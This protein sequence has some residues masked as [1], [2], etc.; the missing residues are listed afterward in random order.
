MQIELQDRALNDV[1]SRDAII[2][3]FHKA[4][5][6]GRR[7][8]T[9]YLHYEFQ[10]FSS[11]LYAAMLDHL[12]EDASYVEMKHPEAIR[13]DGTSSRLALPFTPDMIRRLPAEK[14]E[15]WS[16]LRNVLCGDEIRDLFIRAFEPEL[17]KRFGRPASEVAALPKLMLMRDLSAY[18]ISVHHDAVWK[19]ITTQYYL[20][21]DE[22]QKH[23]GTGIYER[24]GPADFHRTHQIDFVPGNAYAF[25]VSNYSWHGVE[26]I[27]ETLRPRNSMM[28]VYF[29]EPGR[30][31]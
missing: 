15:F 24:R 21:A 26:P 13:P 29:N 18:K 9:P 6:F 11:D 22:S 23:I 12:P 5:E 20:P 1:L 2:A 8:E 27:G 7:R 3:N 19:T 25:S 30:E 16:E 17:V 28:L 4:L 14:R 10:P 31:Y